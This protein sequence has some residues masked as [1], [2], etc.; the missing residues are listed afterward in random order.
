MPNTPTLPTD[1]V[2]SRQKTQAALEF[3]VQR[4]GHP[5][6][7]LRL[8][9]QSYTFGSGEGCSVRLDD[10][11]VRE[12]HALLIRQ[13][14][15]IL[16]RGY[17]IAV[18]VNGQGV[19][20]AWLE[21]G[22]QFELG[23]FRFTLTEGAGTF[24]PD[25]GRNQAPPPSNYNAAPD[26][27]PS[28]PPARTG[29]SFL[30]GRGNSQFQGLHRPVVD[31][32]NARLSFSEGMRL[33][34]QGPSPLK[35]PNFDA[36]C[37]SEK[38]AQGSRFEKDLLGKIEDSHQESLERADA[39]FESSQ[40]S[41]MAVEKLAD[42]MDSLFNH[43]EDLTSQRQ[44]AENLEVKSV[45]E[46]LEESTKRY[47]EQEAAVTQLNERL[48]V[49]QTA[50]DKATRE[51]RTYRKKHQQAVA[52][53]E[54]LES[55]LKEAI[56]KH[57]EQQQAWKVE[58]AQLQQS[59][60]SLNK[61]LSDAKSE[62]EASTRLIQ[63]LQS[64]L[65]NAVSSHEAHRESWGNEASELN[66]TIDSLSSK[67]ATAESKAGQLQEALDQQQSADSAKSE[68][69]L[70]L[71]TQLAEAQGRL[72][73]LEGEQQA[74]LLEWQQEREELEFKIANQSAELSQLDALRSAASDGLED[75][76][77]V[78]DRLAE[79]LEAEVSRLQKEQF[80]D[81]LASLDT[82][83]SIGESS[84]LTE[85]L[86]FESTPSNEGFS[87]AETSPDDNSAFPNNYESEE[88]AG[89]ETPTP[90]PFADTSDESL[91]DSLGSFGYQEDPPA[92][93]VDSTVS[94][95]PSAQFAEFN[96]GEQGDQFA[97]HEETD[98]VQPD[99]GGA[100][101]EF[102]PSNLNLPNA[103]DEQESNFEAAFNASD[104]NQDVDQFG[105][106]TAEPSPAEFATNTEDL[107]GGS[108]PNEEGFESSGDTDF[109]STSPDLA[110]PSDEADQNQETSSFAGLSGEN[111][112]ENMTSPGDSTDYSELLQ[113][114]DEA[115]EMNKPGYGL[116]DAAGNLPSEGANLAE[117]GGINA[118]S[119]DYTPQE[120]DA[121][122]QGAVDT[123][124]YSG[125]AASI[126]DD[127]SSGEDSANSEGLPI[128]ESTGDGSYYGG[129]SESA[130]AAQP[131]ELS[132]EPAYSE[133]DASYEQPSDL[134]Q[135]SYDEQPAYEPEPTYEQAAA[136][137]DP[138]QEEAPPHESGLATA[139]LYE[140]LGSDA[141]YDTP[142]P[143]PPA[144]PEP[145]PEPPAA[146]SQGPGDDSIEDYMNKLLQRM[147][148]D[149]GGGSEGADASTVAS[150][151]SLQSAE[152]EPAVT[153]P[154]PEPEMLDES[155]YV[156]RS[157][158]PERTDNL[159][160]MRELANSSA[161]QAIATSVRSRQKSQG[162]LRIVLSAMFI[163]GAGV[164][165]VLCQTSLM[166]HIAACGACI[167]LAMWTGL[168][169]LKL[170]AS[171]S[172]KSAP[173]PRVDASVDSQAAESQQ[174]Q[175]PEPP[176]P[177][178]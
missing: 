103:G 122:T 48:N 46:E 130:E 96:E 114:V 39:A 47:Q 32:A 127:M 12:M 44:E 135:S 117:Y 136:E 145:Q 29:A 80:Q 13:E 97:S 31:H 168:A 162:F 45:R 67:L 28:G 18:I 3:R 152:P 129:D 165:A 30:T 42:R 141:D 125:L 166:P 115:V 26:F 43:L 50:V 69:T 77:Q 139:H 22:D 155:E 84:S 175:Q 86:P 124:A 1:A 4:D 71:G 164:F 169:G 157:T 159:A 73:S 91:P 56:A 82:D 161:R 110:Q 62:N 34:S 10:E 99:V 19:G 17:G 98:S 61:Q 14:A 174:V 120:E 123:E 149:D 9:G 20:E 81:P 76:S 25:V 75:D 57:D 113:Q 142:E 177:A 66:A 5:S 173:A 59:I 119:M 118:D 94:F 36:D 72:E 60:D 146:E 33:M 54:Q 156:P 55:Q 143:Q 37:P 23:Q 88:P 131:S 140:S 116:P 49:L 171:K 137:P 74:R 102:D 95:D 106:S 68:Q 93:P 154:E 11:S 109:E 134:D 40:A 132:Y 104:M 85:S 35:R 64:Q 150:S 111:V 41:S 107:G 178:Q 176:A 133:A 15:G 105:G 92:D 8:S 52:R 100:T 27:R 21:Q 160:Q 147:H 144:A 170:L 158:A 83:A 53:I 172:N 89:A 65:E 167:M 63:D 38:P 58:A 148:T 7:R 51:A 16:I 24:A 151:A 138:P 112:Y 121:S 2:N 163:A 79:R 87:Q 126:I 6:R 101:M 70:Q 78:A 108:T 128:Q 153:E 90:E